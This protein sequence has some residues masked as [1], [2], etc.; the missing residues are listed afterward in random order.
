[1]PQSAEVEEYY[2][3]IFLAHG[4]ESSWHEVAEFIEQKLAHEV[5]PYAGS[6]APGRT[7]IQKLEELTEECAFA[8]VMLTAKESAARSRAK[9]IH[10]IGFC[11]GSFGREN[12]LVMKEEGA[13]EIEELGGVIYVPFASGNAKAA[14][15]RIQAE[16]DAAIDRFEDDEEEDD[17]D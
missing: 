15:Q 11:Q 17:D 10:E 6:L 14:F 9:I 8:I 4:E 3:T 5:V 1:M 16:I 13:Q 2:L 7:D 12:V